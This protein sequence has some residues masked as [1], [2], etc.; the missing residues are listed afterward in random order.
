MCKSYQNMFPLKFTRRSERR[1]EIKHK[2]AGKNLA[3][4][5]KLLFVFETDKC[6]S[7]FWGVYKASLVNHLTYIIS[8][9]TLQNVNIGR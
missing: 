3:N 2:K 4:Q 9:V 5:G 7:A 6:A 8:H 1:T